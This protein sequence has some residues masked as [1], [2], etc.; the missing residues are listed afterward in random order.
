MTAL[1]GG[2]DRGR[3]RL[4]SLDVIR[5]LAPLVIVVNHWK[6]FYWPPGADDSIVNVRELVLPFGRVTWLFVNYGSLAVDIFF[7][8]SGFIFFRLYRVAIETNRVSAREFTV[9][10]FSRLY[11]LHLV[12]LL[13]ATVLLE[14][15]RRR[16]GASFAGLPNDPLH[17]MLQ[18][19]FASDW[20]PSPKDFNVPIWSVSIEVLLYTLFFIAA[21]KLVL[22]VETIAAASL[23]GFALLVVH[24]DL[25][26]GVASFF[27]GGLA[28]Y[29][30]NGIFARN[31][32]RSLVAAIIITM[33]A[34]LVILKGSHA[35]GFRDW[36]LITVA[37]P[38]L[39]VILAVTE[40]RIERLVHPFR[41]LGHIS[42]STYLLHVPLM[43][44]AMLLGLSHYAPSR[45]F[46]V[47][48]MAILIA[49]SL[50]SFHSFE[51]PAQQF[52]RRKLLS[53]RVARDSQDEGFS[54]VA[55]P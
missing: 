54:V 45:I 20:W 34:A 47:T 44:V 38:G 18:L 35:A 4:E 1:C 41:W 10:R 36:F 48:F 6:F 14:I 2:A 49:L 5:G 40:Q 30:V 50:A 15:Y 24:G 52:L 37:F 39:I 28:S 25:G 27:I 42:Y 11:P 16:Y 3:T 13:I 12:T 7:C 31:V 29:L 23:I 43:L 51:Y 26:R 46:F 22:R 33:L 8:L 32:S 21:K 53:K 55:S 9:L 17:F 19:F